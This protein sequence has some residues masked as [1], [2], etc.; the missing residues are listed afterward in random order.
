M[1]EVKLLLQN[2][3]ELIN[4]LEDMIDVDSAV[5]SLCTIQRAL[6]V[7]RKQIIN[8]ILELEGK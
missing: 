3:Y 4:E 5:S 7:W 6:R 2:N 8:E 1:S